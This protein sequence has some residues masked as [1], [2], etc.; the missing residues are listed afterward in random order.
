[1]EAGVNDKLYLRT[2]QNGMYGA[3][4]DYILTLTPQNY[5]GTE[6]AAEI[7]LQFLSI[8]ITLAPYCWFS[9]KTQI[10]SLSI[11]GHECKIM[12]DAELKTISDWGLPLQTPPAQTYDVNNLASVNELLTNTGKV[13]TTGTAISPAQ[14]YLSLQPVR[15]IYMRSPNISSFN[16]IG[17]NGESSVIK[18]IPVSSNQGDMIFNNITS[19]NDFLDCSKATWKTL[20]FHLVDVN[21]NYINLH[22]AD[23][24]FSLILDKQLPDQ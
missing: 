8:P 12:T 11:A 2:W 3:T 5:T 15:N 4:D 14:Y 16:T 18:K 9:N 17:C 6:L 21:S 13:S 23:I 1:V 22:G 7:G 10:M 19:A 24:S 20:E